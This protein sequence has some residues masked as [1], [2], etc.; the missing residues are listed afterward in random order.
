[1]TGCLV[2]PARCRVAVRWKTACRAAL[3]ASTN[4]LRHRLLDS[5]E[6]PCRRAA[7]ATVISWA[8]TA[9]TSCSRVSTGTG[10]LLLLKIEL[11]VTDQPRNPARK[12]DAHQAPRG[13]AEPPGRRRR[14]PGTTLGSRQAVAQHLDG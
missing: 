12:S 8:S 7:S 10:S 14:C 3:P 5:A 6:T 1:M 11:P 13:E 2:R 4:R 9:S